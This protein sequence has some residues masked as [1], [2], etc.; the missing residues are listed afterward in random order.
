MK[1]ELKDRILWYDGVSQIPS[2]AVV[3]YILS[4]VPLDKIVA[5]SLTED[6]EEFNLRSDAEIG[7]HRTTE[8]V[9]DHS[10]NL[11]PSAAGVDLAKFLYEKLGCRGLTAE[12]KDRLAAEL[13][14]ISNKNLEHFFKCLLFIVETFIERGV[15]WGV[16]RGSACASLVLF[17]I[18]VHSVDPIKYQIPLE[19]FFHD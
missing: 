3:S 7:T 4:G 12:Y 2:S 10:W 11:P 16:G 15:V 14:I 5:A 8:P 9:F 13:A 19:E 18:G 6:I 17:L 1:T